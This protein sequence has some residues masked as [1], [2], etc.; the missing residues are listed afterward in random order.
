[1]IRQHLDKVLA[2][3][4]S[5]GLLGRCVRGGGALTIGAVIENT[6]RFVRNMILARLLAPEAFGQMA[7]VLA[8]VAVVEAFSEVGLRQ[9][10]IRNKS[11]GRPEFLNVIW[12]IAVGRGI[13]LYLIGYAAAPY[14]ASFYN[15]P[16]SVSLI[17]IGFIGILFHAFMSPRI[18]LLEKEFRFKAW[19]ALNQGAAVA[20][21]AIGIF[22]AFSLRNVWALLL[23]YIAEWVLRSLLSYIVCPFRPRIQFDRGCYR[24]VVNFSRGIFGMSLL[25]MLFIQTDVF[26]VGKMFSAGMLGMYVLARTLAQIPV[27][28]MSKI[29][30]PILLPAF[31]TILDEK[32]KQRYLLIRLNTIVSILGL[33]ALVYVGLFSGQMLSLAYGPKY[34]AVAVPFILLFVYSLLFTLASMAA[35]QYYAIGRPGMHRNASI[36]RTAF[37][38]ALIYPAVHYFGLAGAAGAR[39]AAALCLIVMQLVLS[40]KLTGIGFT[41]YG[42]SVVH[43]LKVSAIVLVPGLFIIMLFGRMSVVGLIAG[44]VFCVIAWVV[45]LLGFAKAKTTMFQMA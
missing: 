13:V 25:M 16:A 36:V 31:A 14:I 37:F 32:E 28:L 40:R 5:D 8:G 17:R 15:N 29:V 44:G 22:A 4:R 35:Q 11:G 19:M 1:M 7:I 24:E 10:V 26:V 27:T 12:W 3:V 23:A 39:A 18:H 9:N 41:D 30:Q 33:P 6:L 43:G 45:G 38:V 34:A 21:V 42:M 2:V 20:G